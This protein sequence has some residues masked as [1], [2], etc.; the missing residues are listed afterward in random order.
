MRG[1][2]VPLADLGRFVRRLLLQK[3]RNRQNRSLGVFHVEQ[4]HVAKS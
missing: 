3:L 2:M 1:E 4:Y